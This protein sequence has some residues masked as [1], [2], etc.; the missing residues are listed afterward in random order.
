MGNLD[1]VENSADIRKSMEAFNRDCI[2]HQKTMLNLLSQCTYWVYDSSNDT[3][4]PSKFVGF[5]HMT[6]DCYEEARA[7]KK[8]KKN[9]SIQDA[10]LM[11][12]GLPETR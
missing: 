1:F 12:I 4:G 5:Q 11:R 7:A 2:H 8:K 9:S 6:F 3:F 10:S